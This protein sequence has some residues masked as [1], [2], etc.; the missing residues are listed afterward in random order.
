MA[1]RARRPL[2]GRWALGAAGLL[3]ATFAQAQSSS[4][5]TLKGTLA[6]RI[7][8]TGV[9]GYAM[10][11]V[12]GRTPV[13]SGAKVIGSCD[14]GAFKVVYWR[15]ASARKMTQEVKVAAAPA[16][17]VPVPAPAAAPMP[18]TAIEAVIPPKKAVPAATAVQTQPA[19]EPR[20]ATRIEGPSSTASPSTPRVGVADAAASTPDS[21]ATPR[22]PTQAAIAPVVATSA[23][24]AESLR[25]A[26]DRAAL[27][28]QP[29]PEQAAGAD[30]VPFT[31]QAAAF[32]N[33]HREWVAAL[34]LLPL[35]LWFWAWRAHRN[36]YDDAGLPRGPKL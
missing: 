11:L 9:R 36:A 10:D 28:M 6:S 34:L 25:T 8:S 29:A 16:A 2:G 14:G 15:W 12:P 4:C 21:A 35:G 31:T 13:P 27:P 22:A 30:R 5:E 1:A 24:S 32:V 3:A 17:P 26:D 19:P 20:P 23:S 18:P 33:S 7:E